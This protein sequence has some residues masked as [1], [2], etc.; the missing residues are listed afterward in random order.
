MKVV[1]A[2]VPMDWNTAPEV[3]LPKVTLELVAMFWGVE[4]VIVVPDGV[5]V[6]WLVVPAMVKAPVRPLT[7]ETPLAAPP[8]TGTN[9]VPLKTFSAPSVVL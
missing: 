1:V 4:S 8:P 7:E 5:A 2:P 3:T 9:A 6:I